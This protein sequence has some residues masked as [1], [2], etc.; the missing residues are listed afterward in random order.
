MVK[1]YSSNETDKR[2]GTL[3][4]ALSN[5]NN[6]DANIFLPEEKKNLKLKLKKYDK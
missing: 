4:A 1:G 5:I 2:R 6:G 3:L